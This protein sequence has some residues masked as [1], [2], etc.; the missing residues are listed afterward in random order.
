MRPHD[1]TLHRDGGGNVNFGSAECFKSMFTGSVNTQRDVCLIVL[2]VCFF[3]NSMKVIYC[4]LFLM[5][6]LLLK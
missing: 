2:T 5:F 3:E 4:T 6:L 1:H